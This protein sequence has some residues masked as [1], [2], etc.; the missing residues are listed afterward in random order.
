MIPALTLAVP[1]SG[2]AAVI[3]AGLLVHGMRPGPQLFRD[4]PDVVYGFMLQMLI[5]SLMLAAT[6]IDGGHY[7]IDLAAGIA[8]AMLAVCAA[9]LIGKRLARETHAYVEA[10]TGA[11][12]QPAFVRSTLGPSR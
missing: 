9:R 12:P 2:V 6:P 7:F 1:G 5:T 10:S 8:V 4:N 11:Q 3:L